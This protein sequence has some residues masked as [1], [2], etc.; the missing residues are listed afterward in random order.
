NDISQHWNQNVELMALRVTE[1]A[2][3]AGEHYITATRSEYFELMRSAMGAGL[4]IGIMALIKIL[5]ADQHLAPL[6]EAILFSLNYGL[7]FV[8]IHILH[9]SVATKQPAMTAAAIAASVDASDGKTREM[10][11]LLTIIAQTMRS[12]TVAIL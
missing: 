8:A 9:F 3:R 2:S 10:D 6:T 4:I 12:Q 7:G 11:N 1:N 5:T